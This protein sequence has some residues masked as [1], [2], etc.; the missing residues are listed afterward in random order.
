MRRGRIELAGV[1]VVQPAD[2]ARKL[3]AGRLH[4]QADAEIR[5]FLLARVADGVQHALDAALAEAARH[6]DAVVVFELRLVIAI[7]VF[8]SK[9][10]GFDPVQVQLQVV[11]QRA[12]HQ[13]F[14]QRL[15][16]IFVLDILADDADVTS[17]FG[18]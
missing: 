17:S 18:L 14:F 8:A 16:G 13:R 5:N 9:P 4:A 12:V 11:R 15:V 3:D 1:G 2:V 6:Q 7:A 10:F